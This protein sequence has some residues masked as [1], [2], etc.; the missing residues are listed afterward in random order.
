MNSFCSA[1]RQILAKATIRLPW[2]MI[3]WSDPSMYSSVQNPRE[4]PFSRP[5]WPSQARE[6]SR[7]SSRI[8]AT[9]PAGTIEKDAPP[10]SARALA[11]R[12]LRPSPPS[13]VKRD[14]STHAS[15][16][17]FTRDRPASR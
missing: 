3:A 14:K 2:R 9:S 8:G 5:L 11:W 10:F 12:S 7:S 1:L 16:P 4:K 15:S 17:S 13:R 6:M